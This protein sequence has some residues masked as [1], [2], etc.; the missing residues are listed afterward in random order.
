[1]IDY[2]SGSELSDEKTTTYYVL[3]ADNDPITFKEASKETKW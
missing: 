3:L 1:M 2:I